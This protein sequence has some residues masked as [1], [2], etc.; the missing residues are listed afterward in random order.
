MSRGQTSSQRRK[1]RDQARERSIM[2]VGAT[3]QP[4]PLKT[5]RGRFDATEVKC[6][7]NVELQA[8]ATNIADGALTTFTL[9][10]LP[11]RENIGSESTNLAS[12]QVRGLNWVSRKPTDL[13]PEWD[14]DFDVAA[15]G[16]TGRSENQLKF[17][18][19]EDIVQTDITRSFNS[20]ACAAHPGNT[21]YRIEQ[22]VK[23]ELNDRVF[24]IH[25]P[26][27]LRKRST[28][29]PVRG[30]AETYTDWLA[31][32]SAVPLEGDGTMTAAEKTTLKNR[33]E[34]LYHQKKALHRQGCVD[35]LHGCARKCC[36]FEINVEVHFYDF[37]SA[38]P[39][40]VV[41][42]W[43]GSGRA[44]AKNWFVTDTAA[45]NA[46]EVGHLMGFYDE[47]TGGA[48]GVAPWQHPN[49]GYIMC[50]L[51]AGL[52]DYYFQT[53]A[54]WLGNAARTNETW[55]VIDYR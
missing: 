36:I 1:Q 31:R 43:K 52:E 9:K 54:T 47:Y 27:K 48:V 24:K 20:E 21:I 22:R 55:D 14:V 15:D 7:D 2:D 23:V 26:I 25:V 19:Y 3:A 46:H 37:A 11:G 28:I 10:K 53:Y 42:Y 39:A 12:S 51:S 6:G 35:C 13:W 32:C 29:Q 8:D 38:T 40:S 44:D 34:S 30:A 45:T 41:E 49:A 16:V 50:D 4:C 5:I 18:R 17:H 33:I